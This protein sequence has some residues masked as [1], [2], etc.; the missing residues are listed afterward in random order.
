MLWS[1]MIS[2]LLESSFWIFHLKYLAVCITILSNL[3]GLQRTC[4]NSSCSV[5][6]WSLRTTCFV[7]CTSRLLYLLPQW[8]IKGTFIH[9]HQLSLLKVYEFAKPPIH[10]CNPEVKT[11]GYSLHSL[12]DSCRAEDRLSHPSVYPQLTWDKEV[13]RFPLSDLYYEQVSYLWCSC[14]LLG[15]CAL[16]WWFLL[17]NAAVKYSGEGPA[18]IP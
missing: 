6:V 10:L 8:V 2:L 14:T 7:K 12:S 9:Y 3:V 5:H 1:K 13:P 18:T 15:L 4:E 17:S 11:R 16:W